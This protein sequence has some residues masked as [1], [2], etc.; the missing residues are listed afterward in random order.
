MCIR[1]RGKERVGRWG[2]CNELARWQVNSSN[3][4][5]E[6]SDLSSVKQVFIYY[7]KQHNF[8]FPKTGPGY[9]D[10]RVNEVLL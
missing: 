3:V 5:T 4:P 8:F 6:N 2:E 7:C 10:V 9:L 1:D